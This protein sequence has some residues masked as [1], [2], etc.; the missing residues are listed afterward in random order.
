MKLGLR[1]L[2]RRLAADSRLGSVE[3]RYGIVDSRLHPATSFLRMTV[4]DTYGNDE[5]CS[6]RQSDIALSSRRRRELT[7]DLHKYRSQRRA[8]ICLFVPAALALM[9]VLAPSHVAAQGTPQQRA[10]C[11]D[12]ARWLCSNYIPDE[13]QITACMVRNIRSLS[14]RCRKVFGSKRRTQQRK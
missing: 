4:T 5:G 8:I 3:T 10:G 2:F 6:R 7:M 12:E 11:E 1:G 13:D 9:A 14:P